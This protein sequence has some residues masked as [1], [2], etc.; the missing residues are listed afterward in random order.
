MIKYF[1][2]KDERVLNLKLMD[3]ENLNVAFGDLISDS[4]VLH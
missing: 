3:E 2:N 4:I 1:K